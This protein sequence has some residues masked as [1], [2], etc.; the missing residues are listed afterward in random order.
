MF[1]SGKENKGRFESINPTSI[2]PKF[3]YHQMIH[4]IIK[5]TNSTEKEAYKKNYISTLNWLSYLKN[6]EDVKMNI[7]KQ[8]K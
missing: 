6:V 1:G 8:A 5:E 7:Q 3:A 2:D 4:T